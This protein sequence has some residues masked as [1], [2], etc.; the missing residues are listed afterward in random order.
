MQIVKSKRFDEE[1]ESILDFIAKDNLN[2][3]LEFYDELILKIE[4][5]VNFPK[6]YRQCKMTE[7]QNIREMVYKRYVVVYKIYSDKIL[8]I[9]IFSQ[10]LWKL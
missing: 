2:N 4:N 8:I 10:N 9:G 5:I 1:L 3:A 7:E 6:K